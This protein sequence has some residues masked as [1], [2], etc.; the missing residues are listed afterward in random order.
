MTAAGKARPAPVS[1]SKKAGLVF[2]VSRISRRMRNDMPQKRI[3]KSAFLH[4]TAAVEGA[5]TSLLE[6]IVKVAKEQNAKRITVAHV[7]RAVQ[8]QEAG[9]LSSSTLVLPVL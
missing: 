8:Q 5:V 1:Q 4:S 2:S 7:H 9:C 6:S 3:A